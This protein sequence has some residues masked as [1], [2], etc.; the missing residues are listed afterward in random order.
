MSK[1][2]DINLSDP[3]LD[4]GE[5]D[6]KDEPSHCPAAH[7]KNFS[8]A[9]Y[10]F[11]PVNNDD[12]RVDRVRSGVQNLDF[13]QDNWGEVIKGLAVESRDSV[14]LNNIESEFAQLEYPMEF[15]R[16]FPAIGK[17]ITDFAKSTIGEIKDIKLVPLEDE[18]TVKRENID[19]I[20]FID[21]R[22][23]GG[24]RE[25]FKG[26]AGEKI[27]GQKLSCLFTL[28]FSLLS[29]KQYEKELRSGEKLFNHNI[30][31]FFMRRQLFLKEKKMLTFA[32][33]GKLARI[34]PRTESAAHLMIKDCCPASA[35]AFLKII[36]RTVSFCAR[37][38]ILH[39]SHSDQ[40]NDDYFAKLVSTWQANGSTL[41][42]Q[43]AGTR[44]G[45]RLNTSGKRIYARTGSAP[46]RS[47]KKNE[48]YYEKYLSVN[49]PALRLSKLRTSLKERAFVSSMN[50]ELSKLP[51][52]AGAY[53][54]KFVDS[55][56]KPA[57]ATQV[58]TTVRS[59]VNQIHTVVDARKG[60]AH[61]IMI[62]KRV[63]ALNDRNA[64]PADR[65]ADRERKF[66]PEEWN[67]ALEQ[68]Y[69]HNDLRYQIIEYFLLDRHAGGDHVL[70]LEGLLQDSLYNSGYCNDYINQFSE[71]KSK[72]KVLSPSSDNDDRAFKALKRDGGKESN[73]GVRPQP[74]LIA[75]PGMLG[76]NNP[77]VTPLTEEP[78]KSCSSQS[79]DMTGGD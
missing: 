39:S 31:K 1:D 6:I 15:T 56:K 63:K 45:Y 72:R 68:I 40:V 13:S 38:L 55:A 79:M 12:K 49:L 18:Q 29:V 16:L 73:W 76:P 27:R 20:A 19:G 3:A 44:T 25:L 34:M 51:K 10:E 48:K 77:S 32:Q 35:D 52:V 70:S 8:W 46:R 74:I 78:P 69:V 71:N 62:G 43:Q 24:I 23:V 75:A 58:L 28:L 50:K 64:S 66:S 21:A 26:S 36:L 4:A 65:K 22:N 9:D 67:S 54:D 57:A 7:H 42:I 33:V 11:V 61:R 5:Q 2:T 37:L 30:F 14:L 59:A 60:M 17:R 41:I 53:L 47:D